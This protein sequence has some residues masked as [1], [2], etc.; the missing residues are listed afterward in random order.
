MVL[1][2]SPEQGWWTYDTS[3]KGDMLEHFGWHDSI[4]Q[5]WQPFSKAHLILVWFWQAAEAAWEWD[6]FSSG[7]QNLQ[8][9][10]ENG[11]S[12]EAAPKKW[13]FMQ[14]GA[15][16]GRL[17]G[18][19]SRKRTHLKVSGTWQMLRSTGFQA[20]PQ[21]YH[22]VPLEWPIWWRDREL[23]LL[24]GWERVTFQQSQIRH[25]PNFW[26]TETKKF[27]ITGSEVASHFQCASI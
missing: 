12:S 2:V 18:P 15:T 24:G 17:Q 23:F 1:P 27:T 14:P 9:L 10:F 22:Q 20:Q 25:F 5:H 6:M 8:T 7:L 16:S 26:D 3:V 19:V 4:D 11:A 13:R 21:R